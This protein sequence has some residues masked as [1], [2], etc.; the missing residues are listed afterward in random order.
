MK[1]GG[2]QDSGVGSSSLAALSACLLLPSSHLSPATLAKRNLV[3][4]GGSMTP[5]HSKQASLSGG[6]QE[7]KGEG[8]GTVDGGREGKDKAPLAESR[9]SILLPIFL[10]GESDL[11]RPQEKSALL[12]R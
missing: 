4:T 2:T 1:G 6:T 7:L 11:F 10:A 12:A 9:G 8:L 5:G 3:G